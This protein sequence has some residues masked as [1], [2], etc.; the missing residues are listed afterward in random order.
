MVSRSR[1][2]IAEAGPAPIGT[3]SPRASVNPEELG[4]RSRLKRPLLDREGLVTSL[5][6]GIQRGGHDQESECDEFHSISPKIG[7]GRRY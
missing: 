2:K 4:S 7:A 1:V 5:F 3:I 6:A